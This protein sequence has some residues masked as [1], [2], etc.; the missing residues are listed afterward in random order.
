LEETAV[1]E[2]ELAWAA[3]LFEGEGSVRINKPTRRCCGALLASVVNTDIEV[4]Q[5]FQERWPTRRLRS[6]TGLDVERTRPAWVWITAAR[7]AAAFLQEIRPFVVRGIV[8]ARIDHG[9]AFQAQKRSG[10]KKDDRY[11]QYIEDQWNA[12]W[13]MCEL[14]QR[15]RAAADRDR[16]W[17]PKW[18]LR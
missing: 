4:V 16:A 14:N 7:R 9:L 18:W 5:F 17:G 15:G 11:E 12:Y 8:K 10:V 13:W 1:T 2:R 3:G 6:A